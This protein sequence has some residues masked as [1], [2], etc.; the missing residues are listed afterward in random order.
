[1]VD[2]LIKAN[3]EG[4]KGRDKN[5]FIPLHWAAN[6]HFNNFQLI[7][8][9][10]RHYPDGAGVQGGGEEQGSKNHFG[11]FGSPNLNAIGS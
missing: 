9:L 8:E 6:K 4:V 7:N 1:M 10:V 2:D 5:G 11:V 3:P